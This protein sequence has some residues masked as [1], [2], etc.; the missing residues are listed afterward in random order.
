MPKVTLTLWLLPEAYLCAW[1]RCTL[2]SDESRCVKSWAWS[3]RKRL[4]HP[5]RSSASNLKRLCCMITLAGFTVRP[6]PSILEVPS[7][8]KGTQGAA[9]QNSIAPQEMV[10]MLGFTGLPRR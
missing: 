1:K 4:R 10:A 5:R 7:V 6:G 9:G 8:Q 3:M 2:L